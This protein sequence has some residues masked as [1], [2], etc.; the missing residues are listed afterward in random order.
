MNLSSTKTALV[1][2][3]RPLWAL[4]GDRYD[5]LSKIQQDG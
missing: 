1:A 4:G 5:Y 2:G 3:F